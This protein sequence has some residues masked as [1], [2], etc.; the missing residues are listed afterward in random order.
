MSS[1][2]PSTRLS[3]IFCFFS[4]LLILIALSE[5]CEDG[6][7]TLRSDE[8]ADKVH[9]LLTK[10]GFP[11]GVLPDNVKSHNVSDNGVLR[12]QLQKPCTVSLGIRYSVKIRA[13]L[14][15]GSLTRVNGIRGKTEH[16]FWLTVVSIKMNETS[17]TVEFSIGGKPKNFPATEFD[18]APACEAK[19]FD[20]EAM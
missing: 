9:N 3:S 6:P 5:A 16:G 8:E 10:Y 11:K 1:M 7:L 18:V 19:A 20:L 12:V 15:Y 17:N 13:R 2:A 14:A 4:L